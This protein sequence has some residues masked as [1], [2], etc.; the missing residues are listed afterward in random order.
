MDIS[1]ILWSSNKLNH[2]K[3]NV[4]HLKL[5]NIINRVLLFLM[6]NISVLGVYSVAGI[7]GQDNVCGCVAGIGLRRSCSESWCALAM[8]ASSRRIVGGQR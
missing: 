1:S 3:I 7:T 5:P 6:V 8:L 4:K 2:M